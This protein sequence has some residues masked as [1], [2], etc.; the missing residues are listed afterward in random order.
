MSKAI[1]IVQQRLPLMKNVEGSP[2]YVVQECRFCGKHIFGSNGIFASCDCKQFKEG[3]TVWI[4]TSFF[5]DKS[6]V[7]SI[8]IKNKYNELVEARRF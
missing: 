4:V 7:K 3:C 8:E 6:S 1:E 5:E 2:T